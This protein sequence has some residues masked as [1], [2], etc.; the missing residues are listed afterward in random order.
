MCSP[1]FRHTLPLSNNPFASPQNKISKGILKA[2]Q[3]NIKTNNTTSTP[4]VLKPSQLNP[5]KNSSNKTNSKKS[6][7]NYTRVNGDMPM[8]VPRKLTQKV[9]ETIPQHVKTKISSNSFVF[10]QNLKK[11][12]DRN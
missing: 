3:F 6:V 11:M 2:A 10:G 12:S 5:V 9:A 8:V 1:M 7:N 4:F